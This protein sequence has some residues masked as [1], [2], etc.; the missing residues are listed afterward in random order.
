MERGELCIW[1]GGKSWPVWYY[2]EL[3]EGVRPAAPRELYPGRAV[4]YRVKVGPHKGRWATDFVRPSTRAVLYER[5]WAGEE[6]FI[7]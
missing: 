3:P 2:D 4:L 1:M 6:I 5:I 7:K